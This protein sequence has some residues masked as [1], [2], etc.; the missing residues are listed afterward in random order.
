MK[1][2]I[3]VRHPRPGN[4]QCNREKWTKFEDSLKKLPTAFSERLD[5]DQRG[6]CVEKDSKVPWSEHLEERSSHPLKWSKGCRWNRFG[7]EGKDFRG[8]HVAFDMLKSLFRSTGRSPGGGNCHP[9]QYSCLESPMDRGVWGAT[10]HG[11]QR[12]G[13]N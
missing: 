10:V 2:V 5:E 7:G 6:R 4:A 3:Q 9:L 11:L 13:H 1:E 8:G 12:V